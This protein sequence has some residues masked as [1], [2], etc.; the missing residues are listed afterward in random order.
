MKYEVGSVMFMEM[1]EFDNTLY[2]TMCDM[3]KLKVDLHQL[4]D[5]D[6]NG[7]KTIEDYHETPEVFERLMKFAVTA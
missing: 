2:M 1:N 3:V 7:L 6:V 4:P 5:E